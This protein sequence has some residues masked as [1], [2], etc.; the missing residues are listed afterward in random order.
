MRQGILLPDQRLADGDDVFGRP[1]HEALDQRGI[2]A[3]LDFHLARQL[4]ALEIV[5]RSL[6]VEIQC[7]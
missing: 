4:A 1:A 7:R 3:R 6:S 5:E 2:S